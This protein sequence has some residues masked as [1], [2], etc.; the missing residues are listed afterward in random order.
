MLLDGEYE[1]VFPEGFD[2]V[3]W[4]A[5]AKGWLQGVTVVIGARRYRVT[6]YDP[7][8][9]AQ[10]IEEELRSKAVFLEANVLVVPAVTRVEMEKAIGSVV[11]A[12]GQ[13]DLIPEGH[14]SP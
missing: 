3:E 12:G 7:T 5:E 2:G 10:D 11:K 9:L 6:F 1:I 14:R 8:R 13:L 4:E